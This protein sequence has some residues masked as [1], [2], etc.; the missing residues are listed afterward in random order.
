MRPQWMAAPL[1]GAIDEE[2][3]EGIADR[4]LPDM[5]DILAVKIFLS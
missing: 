2:V 1:R 4:E 5:N 3:A